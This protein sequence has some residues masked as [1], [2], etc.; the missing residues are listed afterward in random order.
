MQLGTLSLAGLALVAFLAPPARTDDKPKEADKS[1]IY[2]DAKGELKSKAGD[3]ETTKKIDGKRCLKVKGF[4]A[5]DGFHPT[6]V[7]EDGPAMKLSSE[8]GQGGVMLE[9]GDIIAEVDGKKVT[10]PEEYRDALDKAK[11][12]DKIKVK[13][14]NVRDGQPLTV[15]AS[16]EERK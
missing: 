13:V 12:A 4:F 7:G 10:T 9:E 6:A 14:I 16:A 15:I 1:A 11:E 2:D 8:D 5:K 3:K